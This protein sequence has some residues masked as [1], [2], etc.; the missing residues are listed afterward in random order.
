MNGWGMQAK[1][2]SITPDLPRNSP[3]VGLKGLAKRTE[4]FNPCF[5]RITENELLL[6]IRK[7][8]GIYQLE[9]LGL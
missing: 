1:A 4:E 2:S 7:L 6:K 5:K 8:V 9:L 3:L